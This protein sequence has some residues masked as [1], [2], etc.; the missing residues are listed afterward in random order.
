M[1]RQMSPVPTVIP[2]ARHTERNMVNPITKKPKAK[3]EIKVIAS[4]RQGPER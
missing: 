3:T 4:A 1:I 2:R